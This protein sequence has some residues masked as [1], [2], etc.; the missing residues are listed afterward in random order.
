MRMH[1]LLRR[2]SFC[3]AAAISC[4]LAAIAP[5][6]AQSDIELQNVTAVSGIVPG[7]VQEVGFR[8]MI[9][10]RAIEYNLAGSVEN[11]KEDKSVRFILQGDKDRI[12]QALKA[13]RKGTKKSSNVNVSVSPAP[14][15]ADRNS[16]TVV[17]WTSV[18]RHI[19][20]PYNLVFNLRPSNTTIKKGEAKKIWL[21]I[22]KETV[23]GEDSGKC[24]KDKR[25]KDDDD[26]DD[27]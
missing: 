25:D 18:S 20:H 22:C 8:A 10:K 5:A 12:D 6:P 2:K 7:N 4:T 27:D 11:N 1:N 15:K 16:F 23:T 9:Q 26:Q 21:E 19:L 24:K 14:A 17:G 13:I 3:I